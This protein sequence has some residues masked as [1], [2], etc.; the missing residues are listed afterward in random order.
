MHPSPDDL[1]MTVLYAERKSTGERQIAIAIKPC[2]LR[3]ASPYMPPRTL[4]P[5]TKL[6]IGGSVVGAV[7]LVF[8]WATSKLT[9]RS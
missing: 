9:S 4:P 2:E 8:F 7:A 6:H 1:L 3:G 5:T